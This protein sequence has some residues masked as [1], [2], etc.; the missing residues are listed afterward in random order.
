MRGFSPARGRQW[1]ASAGE[2]G[3]HVCVLCLSLTINMIARFVGDRWIL[4]WER[5]R[6]EGVF[7]Y[8]LGMMGGNGRMSDIPRLHLCFRMLRFMIL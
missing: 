2:G 7:K 1:T 4:V 3:S 6:Q 5:L 8:I